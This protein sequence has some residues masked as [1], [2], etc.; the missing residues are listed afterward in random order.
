MLLGESLNHKFR[1][2]YHDFLA[3]TIHNFKYKTPKSYKF[4]SY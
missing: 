1:F 3:Y 4:T 2:K